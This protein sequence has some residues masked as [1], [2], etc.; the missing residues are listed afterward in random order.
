M[1]IAYDYIEQGHRLYINSKTLPLVVKL[2]M[3]IANDR[4]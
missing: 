1:S 3:N 4:I 2:I